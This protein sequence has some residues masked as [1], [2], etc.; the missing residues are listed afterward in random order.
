MIVMTIDGIVVYANYLLDGKV[1]CDD[2]GSAHKYLLLL[3][4]CLFEEK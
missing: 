1:T 4:G 3:I 2:D